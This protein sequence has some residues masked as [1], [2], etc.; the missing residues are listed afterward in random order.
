VQFAGEKVPLLPPEGFANIDLFAIGPPNQAKGHYFQQ[1]VE[2]D[3]T[4]VENV[5]HNDLSIA[6]L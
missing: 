3:A 1:I 6:I 2:G 4:I 5:R